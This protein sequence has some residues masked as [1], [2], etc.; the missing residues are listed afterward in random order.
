MNETTPTPERRLSPR[1]L[2]RGSVRVYLRLGGLDLGPDLGL[3]LI[4]LSEGGAGLLVKE[5]V[6]IGKEVSVGLEGQSQPRPILRVANVV[7]CRP[8]AEGVYA[9]G[10]AFQKA[11]PYM[12]YI[13]LT[14]PIREAEQRRPTPDQSPSPIAEANPAA[15][16]EPDDR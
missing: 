6:E 4:D 14:Q 8:T 2:P 5:A 11:L 12:D 9:I 7:W 10:V 15:V 16:V 3:S 1:R 13:D